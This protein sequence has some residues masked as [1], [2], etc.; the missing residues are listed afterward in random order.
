MMASILRTAFE[1]VIVHISN[2]DDV[3]KL[4]DS[5]EKQNEP[6]DHS[7]RVL[8]KK[9][10]DAEVTLRTDIRILINECRHLQSKMTCR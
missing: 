4:V 8:E 5:L 3:R 10:E 1:N 7:I 6:V 2:V 9:A